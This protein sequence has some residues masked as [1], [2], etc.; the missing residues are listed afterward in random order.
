MKNEGR[1]AKRI[2][3][4]RDLEAYKLAFESA[5]EIFEISKSFPKEER[6]SLTDQ[7]HRSS[8]S[9]CANLAEG[10][11]KRRYK[12][13]FV[14][15]LTDAEQEAAETQTWLE[16][17]LKC[18]YINSETFKR[19]DEKYEHIFAMLITMERKADSFCKD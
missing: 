19:M 17:A 14:N 6:Y 18:K 11:R 9:V 4:V 13:V 15:K 8:R 16:F 5:M 12:A 3:S 7:V 2:N 1:N 10:W